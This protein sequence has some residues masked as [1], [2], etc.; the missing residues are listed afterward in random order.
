MGNRLPYKSAHLNL[1]SSFG[2]NWLCDLDKDMFSLDPSFLKFNMVVLNWSL[3]VLKCNLTEY[4]GEIRKR[5]EA[6][7]VELPHLLFSQ[8]SSTFYLFKYWCFHKIW[9][10]EE[11]ERLLK[12]LGNPWIE[13]SQKTSLCKERGWLFCCH[14]V[15]SCLGGAGVPSFLHF[16]NR[17]VGLDVSKDICSLRHWSLAVQ[18]LR[19]LDFFLTLSSLVFCFKPVLWEVDIHCWCLHL[20]FLRWCSFFRNQDPDLGEWRPSLER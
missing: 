20:P 9:L 13:W 17:T 2:T 14:W 8:S 4:G 5:K 3:R 15:S 6:E 7:E 16:Y 1:S 11:V 18:F 12:K 19:N 10:E